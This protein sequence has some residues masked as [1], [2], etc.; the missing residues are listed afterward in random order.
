MA[1]S[2][3][4]Q[5]VECVHALCS[6]KVNGSVAS[7]DHEAYKQRRW[8]TTESNRVP[9][10]S[11][12]GLTII[13]LLLAML[14]GVYHYFKILEDILKVCLNE[15]SNNFINWILGG[16]MLGNIIL[17]CYICYLWRE[18]AIKKRNKVPTRAVQRRQLNRRQNR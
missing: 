15:D 11:L 14:L 2:H 16:S 1:I 8:R 6:H 4:P 18:Q 9:S 17:L 7:L 5:V 13:A 10:R 3:R 12:A